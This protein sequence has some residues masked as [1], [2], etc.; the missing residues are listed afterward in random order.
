MTPGVVTE[1]NVRANRLSCRP[2]QGKEGRT[3]GINDQ[4]PL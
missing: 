3:T 4:P 2:L 1:K